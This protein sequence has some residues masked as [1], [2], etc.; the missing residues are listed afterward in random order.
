MGLQ[1]WAAW[2]CLQGAGKAHPPAGFTLAARE[3]RRPGDPGSPSVTWARALLL[4]PRCPHSLHRSMVLNFTQMSRNTWR[5][6]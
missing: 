4:L 2:L 5:K 1:T 3:E 6:T